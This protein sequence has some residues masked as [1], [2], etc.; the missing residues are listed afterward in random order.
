MDLQHATTRTSVNDERPDEAHTQLQRRRLVFVR[1]ICIVLVTYTLAFFGTGLALAFAQHRAIC[2]GLT[3]V[4]PIPEALVYFAIATLIFWRKSDDWMALLVALMLVLLAPLSTLPEAIFTLL[5]SILVTQVLLSV[6]FY[7][8]FASFL[9]FFFLFPNGR[10]VPPWTPWVVAVFLLWFASLLLWLFLLPGRAGWQFY[11]LTGIGLLFIVLIA[12]VYRYQQV[13]TP[14]ERQQ[15][16]WA[17]VGTSIAAWGYFLSLYIEV[18]GTRALLLLIPLSIGI[19]VLRYRLY[20]I[21]VL[22]NRTLIYGTL[23]GILILVYFGLVFALQFFLRRL[24]GETNDIT[25]VISTLAIAALFQPLRRRIQSVIDR[26]FYRRKYDAAKI[27][28]SFSATLH[29]EV[30]LNT[31]SE[32]LQA[33]VQETMQPTHVS[34]W[35]RPSEHDGTHRAPWRTTSR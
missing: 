20:D 33:V 6:S 12:Q 16:K 10:F 25:I 32:Q 1:L 8:A 7:L 34:L 15:T 13:S 31:L 18:S 23:T 35:L 24:I 30:D 17:M 11:Y 9:P 3:C 4:L 5:G 2:T 26:R 29:N 27:I 19:A 14:V 22:I 21:D 28:E